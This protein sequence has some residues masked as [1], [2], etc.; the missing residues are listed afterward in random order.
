MKL[1]FKQFLTELDHFDIQI[2]GYGLWHDLEKEEDNQ[3]IWHNV[4]SPD[5]ETSFLHHTPY[6]YISRKSFE[7]Y[8]AYHKKHGKW[9]GRDTNG[10]WRNETT[11][12][13]ETM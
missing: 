13:L 12:K 10:N 6:E 4:K 9:P 2:D 5:G 7:R 3:K 8:V 11:H 1:T